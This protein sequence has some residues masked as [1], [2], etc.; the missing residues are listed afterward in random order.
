MAGHSVA[1]NLL[2]AVFLIGGI[3]LLLIGIV[4]AIWSGTGVV[5][6]TVTRFTPWGMTAF[7]LL[8]DALT[9]SSF[10]T[11]G[12]A[13]IIGIILASYRWMTSTK[14]RVLVARHRKR[15]TRR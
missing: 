6:Y 9:N 12:A 3:I 8:N 7:Y 4:M 2:M 11:S 10:F 5:E 13:Q 14:L 1:A 15:H